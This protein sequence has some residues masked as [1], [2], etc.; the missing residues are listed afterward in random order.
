VLRSD[1]AGLRVTPRFAR[2]S[3]TWRGIVL[4][5]PAIDLISFVSDCLIDAPAR[6]EGRL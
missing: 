2:A 4:I 5:S 3:F 6:G 1:D